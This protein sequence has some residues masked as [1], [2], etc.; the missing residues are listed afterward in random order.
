MCINIQALVMKL[1]P[2]VESV[3]W[4]ATCHS[5]TCLECG[6]LRIPTASNPS[7]NKAPEKY[8]GNKSV[9]LFKDTTTTTERNSLSPKQTPG[10]GT[11]INTQIQPTTSTSEQYPGEEENQKVACHPSEFQ[12]KSRIDDCVPHELLC[13]GYQDC[14]DGSDE[15]DCGEHYVSSPWNL[16]FYFFAV[17]STAEK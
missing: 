8:L 14:E 3:D 10:L 4:S 5:E 9:V 16:M 11:K 15:F 12:C 13:D 6:D 1:K 7:S 2:F 17:S